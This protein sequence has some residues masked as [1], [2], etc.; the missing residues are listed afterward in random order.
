MLLNHIDKLLQIFN[1]Y[2]PY[3]YKFYIESHINENPSTNILSAILH[4]DAIIRCSKIRVF[5][6]FGEPMKTRLP[7]ED[8][9]NWLNRTIDYGQ[10]HNERFLNLKIN[11]DVPNLSKMFKYLKKVCNFFIIYIYITRKYIWQMT[12][13]ILY[14]K[15]I[16]G[17]LCIG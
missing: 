5:F 7:I 9:G 11:D 16:L 14:D 4:F 6:N 8:I 2:N 15:E 17:L 12:R 13:P 3:A 10:M 1:Q